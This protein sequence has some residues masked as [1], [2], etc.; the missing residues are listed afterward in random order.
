M[1]QRKVVSLRLRTALFAPGDRPDRVK[2][3]LRGQADAVV[4]DLE[5][6]VATSE[7]ETARDL[8]TQTLDTAVSGSVPALY[9]RVNAVDTPWFEDDLDACRAVGRSLHGVVLPKAAAAA[10]VL[11]VVQG[12][13]NLD[14]LRVLPIVES[15]EGVLNAY[16]VAASSDRVETLL[17][18]AADLSTELRVQTTP[19][20]D[21]LLLARSQVVLAAAAAGRRRPLDGPYL[22]L[23]DVAGLQRSSAHAKRLGFGGKA[24][25]HP[26]QL[27][28]VTA[29]FTPADIEVDWA[30]R[31]HEAFARA[32]AAGQGSI[33]LDDGTF[34]DYPVAR[35]ARSILADAELLEPA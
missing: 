13:K 30:R 8:V 34:V 6:A 15:A 16:A 9:I 18:G 17:F 27:A 22:R 26:A 19:D 20:G 33:R 28:P 24:V 21:E 29:A 14:H 5:D 4:I 11:R 23:D 25:I 1:E 3:A 2:K 10:D 32:E 31:V 7:K 35:R 12:L